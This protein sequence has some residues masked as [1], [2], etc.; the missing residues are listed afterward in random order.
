MM[1][2]V[3]VPAASPEFWE[4]RTPMRSRGMSDSRMPEARMAVCAS[5][6]VIRVA[7]GHG[8]EILWGNPQFTAGDLKVQEGA[9]L[10]VGLVR[11]AAGDHKSARDPTGKAEPG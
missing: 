11:N 2:L 10:A 5:H 7:V 8:P 6:M 3:R 9:H 1:I 4:M